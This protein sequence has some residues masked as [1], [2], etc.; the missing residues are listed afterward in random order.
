MIRISTILL[1]LAV[2]STSLFGWIVISN[3]SLDQRQSTVAFL[4]NQYLVA[5]AD[6]RDYQTYQ[7]SVIYGSRISNS[8]VVLNPTGYVINAGNPDR[9]VP[10]ACAGT[11]GWL[12]IWQ[13][14][15]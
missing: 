9:L 11:S 8:G 10:K 2:V 14:G 4:N 15:C 3:D 1:G 5:W 6:A 12:V 13:Q 7:A